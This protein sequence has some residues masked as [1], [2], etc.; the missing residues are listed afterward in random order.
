MEIAMTKRTATKE[1]TLKSEF[2]IDTDMFEGFELNVRRFVSELL[3]AGIWGYT[4]GFIGSNI[5]G[6]LALIG[7]PVWL[8]FVANMFVVVSVLVIA[9]TTAAFV[10]ENT[11]DGIVYAADKAKSLFGSAKA[12]FASFE[13]P[14]FATK[15]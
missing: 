9:W 5:I 14:S 10:A 3:I 2:K 13:M 11:Y 15:H 12:R 8:S 1:D 7:M 6:A 4:V